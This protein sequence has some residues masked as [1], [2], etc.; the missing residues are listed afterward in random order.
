LPN[1]LENNKE[2]LKYTTMSAKMGG[3]ITAGFL[4][5]HFLDDYLG[6]KIPVFT[7]VFGMIGLA[8]SIYII[9][10]DTRKK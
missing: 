5:G 10:V 3:V 7:M 6:Y 1:R 4:G 2:W 8:M 9:F